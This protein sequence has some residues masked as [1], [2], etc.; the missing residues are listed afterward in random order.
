[1]QR[2]AQL[3]IPSCIELPKC[4]LTNTW[5]NYESFGGMNSYQNSMYKAQEILGSVSNTEREL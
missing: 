5:P 3:T 4:L 2:E 1:M